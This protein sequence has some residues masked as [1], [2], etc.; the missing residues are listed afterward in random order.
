[1]KTLNLVIYSILPSN[2]QP[3][4]CKVVGLW[5]PRMSGGSGAASETGRDVVDGGAFPAWEPQ[6]AGPRGLTRL[7]LAPLETGRRGQHEC[8]GPSGGLFSAAP[9]ALSEPGTGCTRRRTSENA[10]YSTLSLSDFLANLSDLMYNDA[11]P[12]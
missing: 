7:A 9:K 10:S 5:P 12:L 2:R 4:K 3:V 1:M 6:T 11:L 8:L